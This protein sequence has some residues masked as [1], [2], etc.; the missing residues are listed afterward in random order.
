MTYTDT[1]KDRAR[2]KKMWPIY[3]SGYMAGCEW[4]ASLV[5]KFHLPEEFQAP[6]GLLIER[7]KGGK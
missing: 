3:E 7:I 2:R 1:A 4:A 6:L 5:S